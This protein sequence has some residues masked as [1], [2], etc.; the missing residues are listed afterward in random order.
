[1]MLGSTGVIGVVATAV[2]R[3]D[4]GGLPCKVA[5]FWAAFT[6]AV[7]NPA[8][9]VVLPCTLF[10]AL[11]SAVATAFTFVPGSLSA[12]ALTADVTMSAAA[13]AFPA[14]VAEVTAAVLIVDATDV[15]LPPAAATSVELV[16]AAPVAAAVA[17][18][19]V[20]EA[21]GLLPAAAAMVLITLVT[22]AAFVAIVATAA[23]AAVN[24]SVR[25]VLP[26]A[27]RALLSDTVL[28]CPFVFEVTAEG[29]LL[30]MLTDC[31]PAQFT[32]TLPARTETV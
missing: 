14:A 4:P 6:P 19:T 32:V 7:T 16:T 30:V 13:E 24:A 25:P 22:S 20:T 9:T 26:P 1:M 5:G 27:A 12:T 3:S 17:L 31:P 15:V 11:V 10:D 21:V 18:A 8:L 23:A 28:T 2:A 29:V